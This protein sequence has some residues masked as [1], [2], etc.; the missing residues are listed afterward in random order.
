MACNVRYVVDVRPPPLVDKS[1][2]CYEMQIHR[3]FFHLTLFN[4]ATAPTMLTVQRSP[5][6][7]WHFN[8]SGCIY[9]T[10]KCKVHIALTEWTHLY[11][12]LICFVTNYLRFQFR[13]FIFTR[14]YVIKNER[15]QP[16]DIH[17]FHSP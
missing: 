2:R 14:L 8:C 15:S 4:I 5:P 1:Q 3:H 7:D 16:G 17:Y 6:V 9:N 12:Y 11:Q 10:E 13:N